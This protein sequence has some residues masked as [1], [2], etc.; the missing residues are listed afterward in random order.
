MRQFIYLLYATI[1]NSFFVC[2]FPPRR[3]SPDALTKRSNITQAEQSAIEAIHRAVE[4]NPHL[5]KY[6]L[7][8][9]PL[10]LPPEHIG[11]YRGFEQANSLPQKNPQYKVNSSMCNLILPAVG[12]QAKSS[13]EAAFPFFLV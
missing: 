11:R 3:Y 2:N 12:F 1:F 4:F 9:K 13:I 5:P 6:L 7:E 8:E 10:I